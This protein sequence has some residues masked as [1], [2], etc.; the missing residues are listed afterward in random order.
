VRRRLV[1][2]GLL[3]VLSQLASGCFPIARCVIARFRAN[4]PC[5]AAGGPGCAP[6]FRVPVAVGPVV[7]PVVGPAA[8][9]PGCGPVGPV[10]G[11][12]VGFAGPAPPG[13]PVIGPAGGVPGI[14]GPYPLHNPSIETAP[15]GAVPGPMPNP[16]KNGK[17]N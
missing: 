3:A 7:G 6:A 2:F 10:E 5:I 13:V 8:D 16:A 4:H 1:V 14:T 11:Y 15:G 9:C 12:P 17:G